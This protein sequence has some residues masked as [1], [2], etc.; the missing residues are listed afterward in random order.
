MRILLLGK[1]GQIGREL[2]ALLKNNINYQLLALGRKELNLEVYSK[3]KKIILEFNPDIVIN[4]AAYTNVDKSEKEKGL[5]QLI[6]SDVP[7]YIARLCH[8]E[9]IILIHFS[10]DY[11]FDGQATRKYKE[12]D[13]ANPINFYGK[14]KLLGENH[15]RSERSK[16]IIIRT[17][18]VYSP[19]N[20]NFLKSIIEILETKN[21]LKVIDDQFGIPTSSRFI[22]EMTFLFIEKLK[23]NSKLNIFGTY[24]VVPDGKTN[25]F[26][27][28]K[29]IYN[30]ISNNNHNVLCNIK[31][32]KAIKSKDYPS[33]A[34]RP[35]NSAMSN[36]KF[37]ALL[38][39]D[40][41]DWEYYLESVI[42][43][44]LKD[45]I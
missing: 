1:K 7:Q 23:G 13:K 39:T 17:S 40:I 19:F 18:W 15:I 6:N 36:D 33:F 16:H 42:L 2:N 44:L 9:N 14:T 38:S 29:K 27:F 34:I 5:C 41:L 31:D 8:D 45:K 11:V 37:K 21:E 28:S 10:T 20:K 30:Y 24:H 4:S 43:L 3:L 26:E 12:D 25:W 35:K 22:A 32:I